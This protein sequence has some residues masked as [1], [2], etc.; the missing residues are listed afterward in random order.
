MHFT[1]FHDS[2]LFPDQLTG[3][4]ETDHWEDVEAP[5]EA[6]GTEAEVVLGTEPLTPLT[7]EGNEILKDMV[8]VISKLL[9]LCCFHFGFC[10]C[11]WPTSYE[12]AVC[13]SCG[14]GFYFFKDSLF[15]KLC[16]SVHDM[17]GRVGKWVWTMTSV[18]YACRGQK[19]MSDPLV[20][21]LQTVICCLM[22]VNCKLNSDPLSEQSVLSLLCR[23]QAGFSDWETD[24][25]PQVNMN[26]LSLQSKQN[27]GQY[28]W[29]WR[30]HLGIR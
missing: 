7:R 1:T 8:A 29:L 26:I 20:L 2:H 30:S 9:C 28:G 16:V 14:A 15:K 11:W 6:W 17:C 3:L 4:I 10:V 25:L 5:E 22:W 12:C 23:P 19:M 21:E 13:Q 27:G 24:W 18:S